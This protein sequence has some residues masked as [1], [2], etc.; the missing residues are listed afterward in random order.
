MKFTKIFLFIVLAFFFV[1][2]NFANAGTGSGSVTVTVTPPV[3]CIGS[4]SDTA[5][6]SLTCGGGVK[7]QVYT[8]TTPASNGGTACPYANGAT[9]WGSTSCNTQACVC[10][11]PLTQTQ[12]V[13]CPVGYSGSITQTSTKS[14]YP[15]CTFGSWVT[16]SN[17]CTINTYTLTVNTTGTG[18]GTVGG[19]GVKN[20]GTTATATAS[21]SAD[22]YFAGWSGSC[23]SSGQVYMDSAKTCTA[24]FTKTPIDGYWTAWSAQDN[25]CGYYAVDRTQT[26]SC[27]GP[28]YGGAS[29]V[30]SSTQTYHVP[31]CSSNITSLSIS[32][33]TVP[34]GGTANISY[35]CSNGYY[36]HII[37]DSSWA[38]QDTGYYSSRTSTIPAQTSPGSHYAMAYCYNS[39]WIPST[40]SW[41]Y[42]YYTV[43]NAPINGSC[44]SSNGAN[45]YSAPTTGLC[46]SGTASTSGAWSWSCSG[47]YGGASVSCSANLKVDGGWSAWSTASAQCGYTGTQTRTCTNPTPANGGAN[48]VGSSTQS[49]TNSPCPINGGWSAWS[50]QDNTCGYYAVDRTQ[51][52]TCT[53]PA[54]AYGGADCSGSS[55]QSY[56]VPACSSNITSLY[57][58]PNV[59]PYGGTANIY[60]SCTNGYY[61]HLIID[62][63]WSPVNDSGY[64]G[65]RSPSTTGS[66]AITPGS[67][68]A[69]AYCYNS[70][71][72]PSANSW[73]RGATFYVIPPAPSGLSVSPSS[74]NNNWLNIS[75]NAVSGATNYKVYRNGSLVYD[76]SGTAFSDSGLSLEGT[77]SYVVNASNA[78]GT[79][80]NSGAVSGTVSSNCPIAGG[81]SAWSSFGACSLSCGGGTQS[82]SRTCTNPT[83]AY[84]G[85]Y[86]V[87]SST[88]SQSCNTQAC[89][90][91][92]P[93]SQTESVSCPYGYTG[94]ITQ[95]S[96]KSAY[97][98]CTFGSW[99][100][101][102][103]NCTAIPPITVSLSASP[104]GPLVTPG[105]T[106]LTWTTTGNPTSC[107]ASNYWSGSKTTSGG[108]ELRSGMTVG[109]S[110]FIITCSKYGV[111][112]ATASVNVSV[113]PIPTGSI[114]ATGC[115][116]NQN[117]SSCNTSL[118][119]NT[120]NPFGTSAVTTNYPS[121]GTTVATANSSTGTPYGITN[122]AT[123]FYLYNNGNQLGTTAVANATCVAGTVWHTPSG[124]CK[125]SSGTLTATNCIIALGGNS[126]SST[127]TW[128]T[129]NPANGVTSM[130]KTP[131]S[132][133]TIV[134]TA[135]NG[136]TTYT[137]PYSNRIFVLMHSNSLLSQATATATCAVS[138]HW[139]GSSCVPDNNAPNTPTITG[140]TD[141]Y[142]N[143][144]QTFNITATDPDG[145]TIRYGIDW[146][147]DNV[148]D[149]WTS[150]YVASGTTMF[151]SNS[152]VTP[153]TYYIK[154]LAQDTPGLNS[155]W[156]A[157]FTV[158][159][160][161]PP[162]PGSI[163][164]FTTDK[165]NIEFGQSVNLT[166]VST[167]ATS[168]SMTSVPTP[169]VN[170]TGLPASGTKK[171]SLLKT[172]VYSLIC[173]GIGGSSPA[174]Q[175]T[176]T[177]GKIKPT[178]KEI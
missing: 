16:T 135:N 39:D 40:N 145:N 68:Y 29:C 7:Q 43:N 88:Q 159:V 17:T 58:S 25:T 91:S 112:D 113:V 171:L 173:T 143:T 137:V 18:S 174:G 49:Y 37:L 114:T 62:D 33:T 108:S 148:A 144:L 44:G 138:T 71:W 2:I 121:S 154:V 53:N 146:N 94:S 24:T 74:C 56:H 35:S 61:S 85:A 161:N 160:T 92:A 70:D 79:S 102:S 126:C 34:Y 83:P 78:W 93:L 32:P 21:P 129:D 67:H 125:P 87:G 4:W 51:T 176:V 134:A 99:I 26:R 5:T 124:K 167:D 149:Y 172:T 132:S 128:T 140:N 38:W 164:S 89:V 10:S 15:S 162:P 36:S 46:N 75:W 19:G 106:T 150:P 86:C 133:G 63:V 123:A 97:P 8:I 163:V 76:G 158:H 55:T 50:T 52:R 156:S 111:S 136:T 28:Y 1:S 177:V 3:N 60:Y 153:G 22:S 152:W 119:W 6:C 116:I 175:V 64:Y 31:A 65:S 104:T 54:P 178:V 120:I 69:M 107:T 42:V 131:D 157:L 96:T 41:S 127:L 84:G 115:F 23:N 9:Q 12:S 77:Y 13:S 168:C 141:F 151:G 11:A 90:C 73:N 166:W 117:A 27:V 14:A 122:G 95:T 98:S 169:S 72:I 147:N 118:V 109:T 170:L 100:E 82:Q 130:V 81:W 57:V 155:P 80:P 59:I 110:N 101:T 139:G 45:L 105:S 30:G 66:L 47:Q 142:I 103:R 20:Y 48:C 165:P